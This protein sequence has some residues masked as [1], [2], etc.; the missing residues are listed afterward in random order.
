MLQKRHSSCDSFCISADM[1]DKKGSYDFEINVLVDPGKM[2]ISRLNFHRI[3]WRLWKIWWTQKMWSQ[4][5]RTSTSKLYL[6]NFFLA[7]IGKS[8]ERTPALR[9]LLVATAL[10]ESASKRFR[11]TALVLLNHTD[12]LCELAQNL[13]PE[14]LDALQAVSVGSEVSL[15]TALYFVKLFSIGLFAETLGEHWAFIRR[16]QSSLTWVLTKC[17]S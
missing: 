17:L 8:V 6:E 2:P 15:S 10:A 13:G 14:E 3:V 9:L 11:P 16:K 12:I 1:E 4:T 7:R 5:N